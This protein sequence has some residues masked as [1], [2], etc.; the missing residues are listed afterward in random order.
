M[1]GCIAST[2]VL[3]LCFYR[4]PNKDLISK[5]HLFM[6]CAFNTVG[7]MLLIMLCLAKPSQIM[8]YHTQDAARDMP[9]IEA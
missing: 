6:T 4:N 7:P 9:N 5:Q 3:V 2:S 1:M 8:S